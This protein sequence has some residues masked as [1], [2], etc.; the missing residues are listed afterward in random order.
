MSRKMAFG[1]IKKVVGL[2]LILVFLYYG[3]VSSL[4]MFF[5]K[6]LMLFSPLVLFLVT[7][8]ILF[9]ILWMF[10]IIKSRKIKIGFGVLICMSIVGCIAFFQY[11]DY[12]EHIPT[13]NERYLNL[14]DYSPFDPATK[15]VSLNEPSMLKIE[16]EL[17]RM[18]GATALYPLYAAFAQATYPEKHYSVRISEV[19]CSKTE[20]AYTNLIEGKADII[21]CAGPSDEQI[22]KAKKKGVQLKLTPI[23]REAF[24]FFV[25]EKN[26]IRELTTQEI[27]AIYSGEIKNWVK[28]GGNNEPIRAFQRPKNS[29]SQTMLE[30]IMGGKPLM[31]PLTHDV[32]IT[33][34]E[35]IDNTADYKNFKNAIGYSFLFFA[36]EMAKNR[37][38]R[39][40]AID[41]VYPNRNNIKNGE[42]PLVADFYA[43]TA[44]S[45]NPNL[46]R[47]IDW[48]RSPQGQFL[49][50]KTGY[51]PI[52]H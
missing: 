4:I 20:E 46:Q 7:G 43:V 3:F 40:L 6:R 25:N 13:V 37:Q 15:A 21:F 12:I 34:G 44:G 35:I 41:G 30:K 32:V 36:T 17:P 50:E 39:L 48:I 45:Q 42:Y 33:M 22:E 14:E 5:S 47:L 51:T 27:R 23:G 26:R 28:V 8:V 2:F 1:I 19:A 9:L 11:N 49:V 29:G 31:T 18:D 10:D 24:V 16:G 38:I 52:I